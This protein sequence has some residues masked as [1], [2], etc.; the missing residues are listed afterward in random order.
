MLGLGPGIHV[1]FGAGSRDVDGR[2]KPGHDDAE[3]AA[4]LWT[5]VLCDSPARK[6]ERA[7]EGTARGCNGRQRSQIT[8]IIPTS[9]P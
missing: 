7:R 4:P 2:D 3:P 5:F 8:P 9:P 6:R 1:L